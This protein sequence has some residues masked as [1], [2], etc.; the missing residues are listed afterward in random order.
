MQKRRQFYFYKLIGAITGNPGD[1]AS[2]HVVDE[3][4]INVTHKTLY[5]INEAASF[6][7]YSIEFLFVSIFLRKDDVYINVELLPF[8]TPVISLC[9][10]KTRFCWELCPNSYL[11][12]K[13][14][15]MTITF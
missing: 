11:Q 5:Q 1:V 6:F 4:A 14:L 13:A 8:C 9:F 7:Q 2:L 15:Q 3:G 10:L 12:S